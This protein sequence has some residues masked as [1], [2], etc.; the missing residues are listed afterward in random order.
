MQE[1]QHRGSVGILSQLRD[2]RGAIAEHK[3]LPA[4]PSRPGQSRRTCAQQFFRGLP[5]AA[6]SPE[7]NAKLL[8][9]AATKVA[10]YDAHLSEM[11]QMPQEKPI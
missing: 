4:L 1:E 11:E 2:C 10:R 8:E 5:E 9:V 6:W 3:P 7:L